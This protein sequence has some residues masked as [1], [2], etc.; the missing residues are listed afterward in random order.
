MWQPGNPIQFSKACDFNF[1]KFAC[2]P[3]SHTASQGLSP[4]LHGTTRWQR[5]NVVEKI[6]NNNQRVYWH[7]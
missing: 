6:I 5:I 7:L 2:S 4:T 1:E 3:G